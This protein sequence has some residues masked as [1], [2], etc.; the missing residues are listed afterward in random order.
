MGGK[1]AEHP[2][3]RTHDLPAQQTGHHQR[4]RE[5]EANEKK[6][7]IHGNYNNWVAALDSEI[8]RALALAISAP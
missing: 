5:R 2:V 1:I 8:A 4:C 7:K 3:G 6:R